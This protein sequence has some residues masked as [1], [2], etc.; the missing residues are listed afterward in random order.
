MEPDSRHRGGSCEIGLKNIFSEFLAPHTGFS[1]DCFTIVHV[2]DNLAPNIPESTRC[3]LKSTKSPYIARMH[4]ERVPIKTRLTHD[5]VTIE[6][7]TSDLITIA[8]D[9]VTND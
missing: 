2:D 7:R 5:R 4:A 9:R 8:P 3:T 1:N 6:G